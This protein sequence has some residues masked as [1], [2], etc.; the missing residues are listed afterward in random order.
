MR[1]VFLGLGNPTPTYEKTRHNVG[2]LC[3]DLLCS[4]FP[5]AGWKKPFF[6]P[7]LESKIVRPQGDLLLV[8]PLT[9]MNR[10]G[11]AAVR[12]PFLEADQLVVVVDN[13]DL[14][15]GRIRL[16]RGGGDA[17]HNGLKSLQARLETTSY[18]RLYIGIGRPNQGTVIDHVLGRIPQ[19]DAIYQGIEKACEALLLISEIGVDKAMMRIN[20]SVS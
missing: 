2:F 11:D 12:I 14:S 10:S 15:P 19:S 6:K 7:Y 17:G 4:K 9:Y 3:L 16:K 18:L 5:E 13:M 1:Q 8:K 20:S